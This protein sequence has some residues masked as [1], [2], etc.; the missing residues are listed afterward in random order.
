MR[1]FTKTLSVNPKAL[2]QCKLVFSGGAGHDQSLIHTPA[3]CLRPQPVTQHFSPLRTF[4][5]AG[6]MH[7]G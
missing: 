3:S 2:R 4:W 5:P 1:P 7:I 6:G